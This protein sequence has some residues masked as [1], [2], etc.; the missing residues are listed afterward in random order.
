MNKLL[1]ICELK[2]CNCYLDKPITL[3]CGST[4]CQQHVVDYSLNNQEDTKFKCEICSDE[5]Q[6]PLDGFKINKRLFEL[7][8]SNTHLS[9]KQISA[10]NSF[11]ELEKTLINHQQSDFVNSDTYLY[12]YFSKL[13]NQID[14]HRDQLIDDIH[15]RSEEIINALKEF[16]NECKSNKTQVNEINF[17]SIIKEKLPQWKIKLSSPSMNQADTVDLSEEINAKLIYVKLEIEK[18]KKELLMN[19]S[20]LFEP[21]DG[22]A[23]G[24]LIIND[25]SAKPNNDRKPNQYSIKLNNISLERLIDDD[26]YEIEHNHSFDEDDESSND[27]IIE[28]T[29]SDEDE[30]DADSKLNKDNTN[31]TLSSSESDLESNEHELIESDEENSLT[32]DDSIIYDE[33][34]LSGEE[35]WLSNSES[36]ELNQKQS[37]NEDDDETPDDSNEDDDMDMIEDDDSI[38]DDLDDDNY[39]DDE[40]DYYDDNND[41]DDDDDYSD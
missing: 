4:I 10:K 9:P 38:V 25:C 21:I 33:P 8:Q 20:C 31:C 3:P 6:I 17:E 30:S 23:F 11:D 15:K 27:D 34:G 37:S 16:E 13:R 32:G 14:L 24:K 19:K 18:L 26:I 28:D 29:D 2:E 35:S 40:N 1:F 41:Y 36:G 22:K 5:H 12:E 39:D 7:I